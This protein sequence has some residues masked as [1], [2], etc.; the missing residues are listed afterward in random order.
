MGSEMCIRDRH[1]STAGTLSCF[2]RTDL[3]RE[4]MLPECS[5]EK[6]GPNIGCRRQEKQPKHPQPTVVA[7][8]QRE[9]AKPGAQQQYPAK[10]SNKPAAS[11]H[12]RCSGMHDYADKTA[13]PDQA[14]QRYDFEP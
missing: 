10:R 8:Y 11:I 7:L 1:E 5:T 12:C 4:G 2:A 6:K 3:R 14:A 13:K 9:Q